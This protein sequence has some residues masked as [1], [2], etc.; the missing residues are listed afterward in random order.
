MRRRSAS[1]LLAASAQLFGSGTAAAQENE[2]ELFAMERPSLEILRLAMS[3]EDPGL[4]RAA[5]KI[6]VHE[7]VELSDEFLTE[8]MAGALSRPVLLA[9]L[10][11]RPR[12][13]AA[14]WLQQALP[15]LG[16]DLAERLQ[17]FAA[18]GPGALGMEQA[19]EILDGAVDDD[20]W[21]RSL[22]FAA[23]DGMSS[24]QA[25]LLVADVHKR[26]LTGISLE[27]LLPC[28][29]RMSERG[30]RH[31]IGLARSL[32][33]SQRDEIAD[34]LSM[35]SSP[36]LREYVLD[37]LRGS[38]ALQPMT[39][40]ML[41]GRVGDGEEWRRIL[42]L[43]DDDRP[44]MQRAAFR[45]LCVE[46]AYDPAL[47]EFALAEP[48]AAQGR[49]RD[50]L[51]LELPEEALLSLLAS[52]D[53]EI[54]QASLRILSSQ[55]LQAAVEA[56]VVALAELRGKTGDAA[57]RQIFAKARSAT[58]RRTWNLLGKGRRRELSSA[59]RA[60]GAWA[61]P[62]MHELDLGPEDWEQRF[63]LIALGDKKELADCIEDFGAWPNK[64][65][66]RLEPLLVKRVSAEHFSQLEK[67]LRLEFNVTDADGLHAEVMLEDARR[68]RE[69]F[70]AVLAARSD[71][72]GEGLLLELYENSGDEVIRSEA[73]QGL[74]KRPATRAVIYAKL[75]ASIG[76][77]NGE[78]EIDLAY[79]V[80]GS[81]QA[82]LDATEARLLARLLL[83][84]PLA[85][86]AVAED[87]PPNLA[88]INIAGR[89]LRTGVGEEVVEAFRSAVEEA[90]EHPRRAQL[91][92]R[93]LVSL[94]LAL[95]FNDEVRI[96]LGPIIGRLI[97]ARPEVEARHLGPALLMIAAG[98]AQV[99]DWSQAAQS[100]AR[101]AGMLLRQ[102]LEPLQMRALLGENHPGIQLA[103]GAV[104]ARSHLCAVRAWLAA[105]DR[106]QA[107]EA[108]ALAEVF[109][110][111]DQESAVQ[112][113]PLVEE[114][115]R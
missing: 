67:L 106:K 70:C 105:G 13:A 62:L 115:R 108:L 21:V 100:Y 25:D 78:A 80:A 11:D 51:E 68:H 38:Y 81:M 20:G 71:L 77:I 30:E 46:G 89:I 8:V 66:R 60:R 9:A 65:L 114:L 22:A 91:D 99:G 57:V 5:A 53:E 104:Y 98:Q 86:E 7:Q 28:L 6:L 102:P 35:R 39:L 4:A 2:H 107:A 42:S 54:Q 10:A 83:V 92:D 84:A 87:G 72:G 69:V 40:R 19:R 96:A 29:S 31:L 33:S 48:E 55:Q 41:N 27:L 15:R 14:L 52:E 26:S 58:V 88:M 82:P 76:K 101:A 12:R 3:S 113:R 95:S 74:L 103:L 32:Q 110:Y 90:S 75:N 64:W 61:L 36:V 109:S 59:L 73:L 44:A 112:L 23:A 34:W 43:L 1:L 49:V 37:G 16:F 47:L 50:L 56:R 97:A 85:A 18:L 45:V 79:E 63:T 93:R 94:L 24:T 17:A 111:G